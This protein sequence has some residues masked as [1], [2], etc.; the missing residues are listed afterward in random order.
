MKFKDLEWHDLRDEWHTTLFGEPGVGFA[1]AILFKDMG[2]W[3]LHYE[4]RDP[5]E[6]I[7]SAS[8]K[9]SAINLAQT[10]HNRNVT[11]VFF[12]EE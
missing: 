10:F 8:T 1:T 4:S 12:D 2:E 6:H 7:V 5:S 11:K 3:H 9:R